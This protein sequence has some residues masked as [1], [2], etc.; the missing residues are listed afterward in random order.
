MV[1]HTLYQM[2]NLLAISSSTKCEGY[3][4]KIPTYGSLSAVDTRRYLHT[5]T[6]KVSGNDNHDVT[7]IHTRPRYCPKLRV[8]SSREKSRCQLPT[9]TIQSIP[10]GICQ[11]ALSICQVAISIYQLTHVEGQLSPFEV[12]L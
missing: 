8:H 9:V 10:I 12:S 2:S 1:S 7:W 11:V 5:L 4:Q 3:L 6:Q